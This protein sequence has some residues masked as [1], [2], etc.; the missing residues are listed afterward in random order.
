[1]SV[2]DSRRLL[3][4]HSAHQIGL[5]VW[6]LLHSQPFSKSAYQ[7]EARARTTYVKRLLTGPS[8]NNCCVPL[9]VANMC[10]SEHRA[11][12]VITLVN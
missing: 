3:A 5:D 10:T 12:Q 6:T 1:M 2:N 9:A 7:A 4:F 8:S 11:G